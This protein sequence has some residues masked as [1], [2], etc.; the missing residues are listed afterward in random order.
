MGSPGTEGSRCCS[1]APWVQSHSVCK[2]VT[3]CSGHSQAGQAFVLLQEGGRSREGALWAQGR[4]WPCSAPQAWGGAPR[5]EPNRTRASHS[6]QSRGCHLSFPSWW[7]VQVP[8]WL[9]LGP[10]P[11]SSLTG[12]LVLKPPPLSVMDSHDCGE[13][14]WV[15]A[16]CCLEA[17]QSSGLCQA[18]WAGSCPAS[19]CE[20]SSLS[21]GLSVSR[22]VGSGTPPA[23]SKAPL[24]PGSTSQK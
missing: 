23:Q 2:E 12:L 19:V 16:A 20:H 9:P 17:S 7:A 11:S 18:E 22:S 3:S 14:G 21:R 13:E 15:E 8:L 4:C 6:S 10:H 5:T 24:E 1:G